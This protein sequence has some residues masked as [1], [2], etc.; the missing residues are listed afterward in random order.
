MKKICISCNLVK[1]IHA[2]KMCY[3][4]YRKHSWTPK[5]IICKRCKNKRPHHSKGLC[6]GCYNFVFHLEKAKQ[7]NYKKYHKIP[8]ELYKKVT[9]KCTLCNFDNIVELHHLDENKENSSETNLIGLCPNHHKMLHDF[10]FKKGIVSQLRER[11]FN[12]P[13]DPKLDFNDVYNTQ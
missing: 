6:P 13:Y 11:G 5:I 12:I 3:A 7:D 1:E 9:K 10:R 4:C 8:L 2:K